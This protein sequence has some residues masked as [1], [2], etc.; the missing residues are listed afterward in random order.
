[1]SLN[2]KT[3]LVSLNIS[4]CTF[5]K[6]DKKVSTNTNTSH[7]AAND[8]GRFNKHLLHKDALKKIQGVINEARS[9]HYANTLDWN[10]ASGTRILP[11]KKIPAYTARMR[12]VRQDFDEALQTF[13]VGY[14][15]YIEYA[16]TR[17]GNMFDITDFPPA[18]VVRSRFRFEHRITPVPDHG[19]FRI[20][21]PEQQL[22]E[23]QADLQQRLR[24][25]TKHAT[26]DLWNR[27]STALDSLHTTL[28][29]PGSRI[30]RSTV[31]DNLVSLVDQIN[32]MNFDDD[33]ELMAI[34]KQI[35]ANLFKLSP[36]AIKKD[37]A[38]R[39]IALAKT[40]AIIRQ[41]PQATHA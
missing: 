8:A 40:D 11:I 10:E 33:V 19:D 5:Q 18:D 30:Y 41:L 27:T 2:T 35:E 20:D 13:L 6:F 32:E 22:H 23:I 15:T 34:A 14:P 7:G 25:A 24:A 4:Q 12:K 36:E 21:I 1:M 3:V 31:H 38:I 28:S 37:D 17:L 29:T 9:Y 26:S 16:R 39:R